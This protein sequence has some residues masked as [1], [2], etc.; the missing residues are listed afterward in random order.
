M[1]G[2]GVKSTYR[3]QDSRLGLGPNEGQLI[4][5]HK[6]RWRRLTS[7]L[8]VVT[9][10]YNELT[11]SLQRPATLSLV[12]AQLL[13]STSSARDFPATACSEPAGMRNA[14]STERRHDDNAALIAGIKLCAGKTATVIVYRGPRMCHFLDEA[15]KTAE[16][17]A[18][19]CVTSEERANSSGTSF[20]AT[21]TRQRLKKENTQ[22]EKEWLK[23]ANWLNTCVS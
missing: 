16:R 5:D 9:A 11:E 14:H 18:P 15:N 10:F 20:Y 21:A 6:F 12:P 22:R 4:S 8:I 3:Y 1:A 17:F 13:V 19:D 23:V 7:C 2:I